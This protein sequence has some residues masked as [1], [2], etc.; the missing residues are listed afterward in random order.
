MKK[1]YQVLDKTTDFKQYYFCCCNGYEL[2][3]YNRIN[4]NTSFNNVC[5]ISE[6]RDR[7]NITHKFR[8]EKKMINEEENQLEI[9]PGKV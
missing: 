6:E 2:G 4:K 9:F 1:H 7:H 3:Y 8:Y 5:L